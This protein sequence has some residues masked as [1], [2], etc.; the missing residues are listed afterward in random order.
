[1]E[2]K[3]DYM[4]KTNLFIFIL[5]L[6]MMFISGCAHSPNVIVTVPNN[7][8]IYGFW[9]GTWHGIISGFSF[10]GSLFDD[11]IK[12]YA[13]NNNGHWYDF[14]F[15]GGLFFIIRLFVNIIK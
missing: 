3:T 15:V 1:M 6:G 2:N 8:H 9:S 4:K 14:G 13:I 5:L 7:I 11:S 10:I 12:V